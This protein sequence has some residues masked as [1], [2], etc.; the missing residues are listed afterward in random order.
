MYL[1]IHL[2][3]GNKGH[4][5]RLSHNGGRWLAVVTSRRLDSIVTHFCPQVGEC[6]FCTL[7]AIHTRGTQ[8]VTAGT[9]L[10]VT[11]R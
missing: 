5:G 8:A 1:A 11:K 7:V 10:D 6:R 9:R 4:F 3:P 2:R